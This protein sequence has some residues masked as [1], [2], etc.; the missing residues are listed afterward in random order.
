MLL[1]ADKPKRVDQKKKPKRTGKNV[2]IWID[3]DVYKAYEAF[4]EMQRLP[5]YLT[6]FIE[7][8]MQ[9]FLKNEGFWPPKIDAK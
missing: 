6:D 2:N 9:E 3:P 5:V 4:A 1:M 8:A 7:L